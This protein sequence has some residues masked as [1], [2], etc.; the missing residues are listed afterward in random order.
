[1]SNSHRRGRLEMFPNVW[2]EEFNQWDPDNFG[3]VLL[4]QKGHDRGAHAAQ[5]AFVPALDHGLRTPH[6]EELPNGDVLMDGTPDG[7]RTPL[8]WTATG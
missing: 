6:L 4:P 2:D 5:H 8:A 3:P 7:R 1:M